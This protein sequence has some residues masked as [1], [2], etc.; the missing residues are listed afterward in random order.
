MGH[1]GWKAGH[2]RPG[3]P[4]CQ[5][6]G[7]GAL[8]REHRPVAGASATARWRAAPAPGP[9]FAFAAFFLFFSGLLFQFTS[10]SLP[11]ALRAILEQAAPFG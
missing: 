2:K 9:V 7:P 3:C 6:C 8:A 11:M 5:T 1:C 4:V 10:T